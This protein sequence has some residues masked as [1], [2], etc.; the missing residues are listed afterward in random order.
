MQNRL[1]LEFVGDPLTHSI[2]NITLDLPASVKQEDRTTAQD[3]FIKL[4][5]LVGFPLIHGALTELLTFGLSVDALP[6]DF[7]DPVQP[8]HYSGRRAHC[9]DFVLASKCS[10][11]VDQLSMSLTKLFEAAKV[12]LATILGTHEFLAQHT[13]NAFASYNDV[14]WCSSILYPYESTPNDHM[15]FVGGIRFSYY[16]LPLLAR[17][18]MQILGTLIWSIKECERRLRR[19][20]QMDTRPRLNSRGMLGQDGNLYDP[21]DRPMLED[22]EPDQQFLGDHRP[23]VTRPILVLPLRHGCWTLR[24]GNLP[25]YLEDAKVK[26]VIDRLIT[27]QA[28]DWDM[29]KYLAPVS[30]LSFYIPSA[31]IHPNFR[32]PVPNAEFNELAGDP[33]FLDHEKH[34]LLS[35]SQQAHPLMCAVWWIFNAIYSNMLAPQEF[36]MADGSPPIDLDALKE[37]IRHRYDHLRSWFAAAKDRFFAKIMTLKTPNNAPLVDNPGQLDA[38]VIMFPHERMPNSPAEG[39]PQSWLDIPPVWNALCLLGSLFYCYR[40]AVE[41]LVMNIPTVKNCSLFLRPT[42][43]SSAVRQRR[44]YNINSPAAVLTRWNQVGAPQR[45]RQRTWERFMTI[46]ASRFDPDDVPADGF[47]VA[48]PE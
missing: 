21:N 24:K 32:Q 29:A 12:R 9:T 19:S 28:P 33:N 11:A 37:T 40:G 3:E 25:N 14:G 47:N 16:C 10:V 31:I 20:I 18:L 39:I 6:A 35:L 7:N 42:D 4:L 30:I 45:L 13:G 43:P 8:R 2:N 46:S 23:R 1:A 22:G 27:R 44:H 15:M 41:D 5:L 48:V 34:V 36:Q 38:T 17:R 26:L